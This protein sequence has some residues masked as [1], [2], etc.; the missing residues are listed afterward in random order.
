[1]KKLKNILLSLYYYVWIFTFNVTRLF[2]WTFL[3]PVNYYLSIFVFNK[4]KKDYL[5]WKKKFLKANLGFPGGIIDWFA[6]GLFVGIF[7]YGLLS[8][9][10]YFHIFIKKELFLLL[11]I[12][13]VV[14]TLI[15]TK[16]NEKSLK[17]KIKK[18][19][20]KKG[21]DNYM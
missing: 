14:F 19:L 7:Y 6:Y 16:K 18:Y 21:L 8:L 2:L 17:N 15:F 11:G 1:M 5:S 9:L 4:T 10:I 3:I 13:L 12:M 20:D